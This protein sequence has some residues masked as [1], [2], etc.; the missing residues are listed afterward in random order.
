MNLCLK[1]R[2]YG[3]HI[4]GVFACAI[5]YADDV[6]NP[7]KS[8]LLLFNNQNGIPLEIDFMGQKVRTTSDASIKYLGLSIGRG[9]LQSAVGGL[10]ARTNCLNAQLKHVEWRERLLMFFF[11]FS[12]FPILV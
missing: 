6:S 3:C 10:Y 1:E 5:A 8:I 2:D 11:L 4:G 9:A 12:F 7:E